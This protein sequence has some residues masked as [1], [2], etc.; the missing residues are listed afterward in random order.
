MSKGRK[1][2]YKNE[3]E[4]RKW[5]LVS[6]DTFCFEEN[7]MSSDP[8]PYAQALQALNK[9]REEAG[10]SSFMQYSLNWVY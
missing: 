4:E 2:R 7:S 6:T 10:P 5:V 9:A 1:Q 8:M 3:C